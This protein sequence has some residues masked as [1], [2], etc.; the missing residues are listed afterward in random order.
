ML[1]RDRLFDM[2]EEWPSPINAFFNDLFPKNMR[3][4]DLEI[5][6]HNEDTGFKI[7]A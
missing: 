2:K 7:F 6:I 3:K 1:V 4:Y 5:S